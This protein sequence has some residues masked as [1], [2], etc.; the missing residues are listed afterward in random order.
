MAF[1]YVSPWRAASAVLIGGAVI[2]A[3]VTY[4]R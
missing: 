2:W 3:I 1:I 4:L